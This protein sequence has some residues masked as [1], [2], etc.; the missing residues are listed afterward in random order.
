MY[1]VGSAISVAWASPSLP[2]LLAPGGPLQ[3]TVDQGTWIV[4][5][6]KVGQFIMPIP[7]AWMMHK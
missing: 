1:N 3:I 5:S 7:A 2:K 6:M 4:S